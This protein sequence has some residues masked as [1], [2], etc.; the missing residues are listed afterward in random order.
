MS[1]LDNLK[2]E[3]I[4]D[5][6]EKIE[7]NGITFIRE[8]DVKTIP[9]DCDVCKIILITQEDIDTY[10][11]FGC[12]EKCHTMYYYQNKEKW[13]KGWRPN[14]TNNDIIINNNEVN[15]DD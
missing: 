3:D 10:E 2:W 5:D 1:F 13:I 12:C 7:Y 14:L 4:D 6:N 11:K 9:L 8:K 15:K